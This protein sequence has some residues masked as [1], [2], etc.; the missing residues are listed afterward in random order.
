L[1]DFNSKNIVIILKSFVLGGAEK[2]A[3][4]LAQYLQNN[5]NCNVYIYSLIQSPNSKLFCEECEKYGIKNLY[6]VNNPLSASGNLKYLKRR[7]KIALFGLKLRKHKP[8]IIIP[9]LNPPS[10]IASLCYKISGAKNTFW[11][12]RGADYYRNDKLEHNAVKKCPLFIA[13]A[14][15]GKKELI[16]KLKSPIELTHFL[17]N[18]S[19]V[20]GVNNTKNVVELDKIDKGTIIIGMIGHFFENKLQTLL[21]KAMAILLKKGYNTHLVL[22][23]STYNS[24]DFKN[25]EIEI[26]NLIEKLKIKDNVTIVYDKLA[27]NILPYLDIGCLISNKEGMP[28]V[29]LEYMAY[30]LPVVTVNHRGCQILL[31]DDYPFYI[32]L[33]KINSQNIAKKLSLLVK[34]KKLRKSIGE[35]NALKLINNFTIERYL[36][37]LANMLD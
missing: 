7:I 14:P 31:G 10:I 8:D 6:T 32:N 13:N 4:F 24:Y 22:A 26:I 19:T 23:T 12:H 33:K 29:I 9:Y 5:E 34:D 2:Q 20:V 25:K 17:P 30:K 11:H 3:L 21:V 18:F 1:Y 28:N 15:N 16:S 36:Q 37:Q 35:Q 27:A